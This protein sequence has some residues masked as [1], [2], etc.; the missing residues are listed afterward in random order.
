MGKPHQVS[1]N[2]FPGFGALSAESRGLLWFGAVLPG[3]IEPDPGNT[4]PYPGSTVG[5]PHYN[6]SLF[7]SIS[8]PIARSFPIK[9]WEICLLKLV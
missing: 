7:T 3:M 2:V 4:A 6:V 1:E 5:D 9:K 8:F